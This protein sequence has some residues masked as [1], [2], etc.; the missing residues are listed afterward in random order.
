[1]NLFPWTIEYLR[2]T[3]APTLGTGRRSSKIS[4][5]SLIERLVVSCRVVNHQRQAFLKG[6]VGLEVGPRGDR[7]RASE[8]RAGAVGADAVRRGA[9]QGELKG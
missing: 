3:P 8:A 1:M 2:A 6:L 5:R 7:A 4:A 9:E